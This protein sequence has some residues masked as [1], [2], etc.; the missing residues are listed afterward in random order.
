MGANSIFNLLKKGNILMIAEGVDVFRVDVP[1]KLYGKTISQSTV[2]EKSGCSIIAVASGDDIKI[3]PEPSTLMEEGQ[4]II[5][6]GN[7]EAETKFFDQFV[8]K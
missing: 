4:S 8:D 2:R 1:K 6:I 3:N 5:L 7:V